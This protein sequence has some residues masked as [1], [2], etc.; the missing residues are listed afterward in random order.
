MMKFIYFLLMTLFLCRPSTAGV[1]FVGLTQ[2]VDTNS[3]MSLTY[4][5][6]GLESFFLISVAFEASIGQEVSGVTFNGDSL[7]QTAVAQIDSTVHQEIWYMPGPVTYSATLTV[8]ITPAA[9]AIVTLAEFSG[10]SQTASI[11]SVGTA[12]GKNVSDIPLNIESKNMEPLVGFG[13]VVGSTQAITV[14][15]QTCMM[16]ILSERGT[17]YRS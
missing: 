5:A 17:T 14:T 8:D 9:E 10:V 7:T 6:Q 13:A 2:K 15:G 16:N 4:T 3:Q 1:T 11:Y 12:A